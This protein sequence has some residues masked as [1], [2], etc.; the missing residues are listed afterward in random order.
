VEESVAIEM[1]DGAFVSTSDFTAVDSNVT[2]PLEYA[3]AAHFAT[4]F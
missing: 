2:S 1:T 3:R 4:E